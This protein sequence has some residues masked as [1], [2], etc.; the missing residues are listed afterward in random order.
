[1][2]E[3]SGSKPDMRFH[4]LQCPLSAKSGQLLE[5]KSVHALVLPFLAEFLQGP[6]NLA[7]DAQFL[8]CTLEERDQ[9][10]PRQMAFDIQLLGDAVVSRDAEDPYNG[11]FRKVFE[12][13][14]VV[15]RRG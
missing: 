10:R 4:P 5:R 9:L 1:M 14:E 7:M 6:L 3:T 13:F 15:L 8:G 2:P 11:L 12:D